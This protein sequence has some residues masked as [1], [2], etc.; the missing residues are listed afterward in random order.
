MK[1]IAI[2]FV[3]RVSTGIVGTATSGR[4]AISTNNGAA[5]SM[6]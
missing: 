5:T 2:K 3:K 4:T 6:K 1:V